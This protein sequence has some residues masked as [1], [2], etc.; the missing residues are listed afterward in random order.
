MDE[1]LD[2]KYKVYQHLKERVPN[3]DTK[4]VDNYIL[5]HSPPDFIKIDME[6]AELDVLKAYRLDYLFTRIVRQFTADSPLD[7]TR[8]LYVGHCPK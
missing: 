1:S 6:A 7:D 5:L 3:V 2:P 8:C 4:S